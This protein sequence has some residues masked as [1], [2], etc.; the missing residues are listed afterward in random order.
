MLKSDGFTWIESLISLALLAVLL[1]MG[2]PYTARLYQKNQVQV[3]QYEIASAIRFSR[4]RAMSEGRALV[5][6]PLLASNDWSNGMQLMSGDEQ[7]F[8]WHWATPQ[9]IRVDWHGFQSNRFLRFVPDANEFATNGY[10]SIHSASFPPVKLV[11]NR[12]G[13]VRF[14]V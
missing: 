4:L 3:I 10:F 13:R 5:L 9:K 11:V 1:M 2:I 7:L 6:R 12:L 14:N 8:E